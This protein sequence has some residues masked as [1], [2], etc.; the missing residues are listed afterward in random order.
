MFPVHE[1]ALTQVQH[2][3]IPAY[4]HIKDDDLD[5]VGFYL[6]KEGNLICISHGS[7]CQ[8]LQDPPRSCD[9]RN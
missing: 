2:T 3:E 8:S 9:Y 1:N 7:L 6:R 5:V 4:L